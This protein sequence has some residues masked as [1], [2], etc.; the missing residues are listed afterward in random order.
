MTEINIE[1]GDFVHATLYN[2]ATDA[3]LVQQFTVAETDGIVYRG[4]ELDCDITTGWTVELIRKSLSNL[5]LPT[6]ISEI[7]AIDKR[8]KTHKLVGK[9]DLW[10]DTNG[11]LFDV[12]DIV[13]WEPETE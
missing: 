4:G 3:T 1:V 11:A 6:S 2:P 9:N 5:N 12:A 7:I 10:R 8:G 13:S